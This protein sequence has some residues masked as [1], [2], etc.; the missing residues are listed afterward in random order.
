VSAATG[1]L[2][3]IGYE[4]RTLEEY[5]GILVAH[6]CTLLCDVRRNP[7]SRK[8]GFSRTRLAEACE[9][10][11]LRYEHLPALGIASE[12]RKAVKTP[13][14]LAALF[15]H[16]R[17]VLLPEVAVHL[18]RIADWIRVG[19][20]VALTCFERDPIECHRHMVAAGVVAMLGSGIQIEHL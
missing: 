13:Q 12:D 2:F 11:G 19:E 16:Y 3:T 5:L 10:T 4:G 20:R 1:P 18:E 17:R 9:A 14:Q 7:F 8:P 15:D 6:E